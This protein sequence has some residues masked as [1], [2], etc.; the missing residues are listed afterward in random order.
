MNKSERINDMMLFLND[1]NSF[2]LRDLMYKYD[3]SKSTALRDVKSLE[4]IGMP[5]YSQHG[6]NGYYGILRNR[7]L[8]PIVFNI[9]EVFALYFSMLTLRAYETTPF[10]LSVEKLKEKFEN[11]LSAEKIEMLR[12]VEKVFS[13]ASIQHSNQCQFLSD[14][15]QYA[16][17][18]KVCNVT[19][20]KKEVKQKYHIQFFDISSTY[21]QWYATGHNF[22]TESPQVFR[23]DKILGIEESDQYHSKP[24]SEFMKPAYVLY[25]TPGVTNFEVEISKKG[26]DLFY[27]EHYP[28]MKLYLENGQYFIRGF[29]NIGEETFI[30][31]YFIGYGKNMLSIKPISLKNL[32]IEK[33]SAL[34]KYCS[35]M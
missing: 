1:K 13:L 6:R 2:N 11:C 17:E 10:H 23:C 29:Y 18:E 4:R 33:L 27:K 15:L 28:S 12:R 24:L 26:I 7:L 21:G 20:R 30:T 8:S 14:I 31:N 9:D 5:I 19:Y 22:E 34:T 25:K 35:E 32:I 3:I 16:I